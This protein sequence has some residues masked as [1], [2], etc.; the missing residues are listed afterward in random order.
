MKTVETILLPTIA[1]LL[2][3]ILSIFL[4]TK[5]TFYIFKPDIRTIQ[6]V[7]EDRYRE[8][9]NIV[10]VDVVLNCKNYLS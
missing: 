1:M 9:I 10:T 3:L 7:K 5:T 8:C 6:Q 4:V 2:I